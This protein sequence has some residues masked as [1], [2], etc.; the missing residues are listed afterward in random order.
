MAFIGRYYHEEIWRY[1]SVK[2]GLEITFLESHSD[3]PGANEL[4][5]NR[6]EAS[7]WSHDDPDPWCHVASLCHFELIC[8]TDDWFRYVINLWLLNSLTT[9]ISSLANNNPLWRHQCWKGML[10][11]MS[12]Q[13]RSFSYYCLF[14]WQCNLV[15][16]SHIVIESYGYKKWPILAW[17]C[18]HRLLCS[19]P[20]FS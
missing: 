1:Q 5:P 19:G 11:Q 8:T 13:R 17:L 3:L 20:I 4:M 7:T 12:W 14:Q 2:Q 9:L 18:F 6:F 10:D 16:L 15:C